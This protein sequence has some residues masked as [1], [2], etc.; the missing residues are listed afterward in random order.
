MDI[1]RGI[2]VRD[3]AGQFQYSR[4]RPRGKAEL[5]HGRI[6]QCLGVGFECAV[7]LDMPCFH[8]PV[9]INPF[10]VLKTLKLDIP[11]CDNPLPDVVRFLTHGSVRQLFIRH[12]RHLDMDIYPVEQRAGNLV[13]VTVDLSMGAGA[14][15]TAIAEIPARTGVHGCQEH[16]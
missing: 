3:G 5:L 2:E 6:E 9:C 13:P 15:M 11:C 1:L 10:V 12:R 7:F 8:L 14:L 4:V 16:E